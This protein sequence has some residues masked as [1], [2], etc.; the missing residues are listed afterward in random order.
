M[1]PLRLC[2]IP[3]GEASFAVAMIQDITQRKEAEAELLAQAAVNEHQA[4]HDALTGLANRTSFRSASSRP[5]GATPQ[6]HSRRSGDHGPRRVQG[7]QRLSRP[8]RRRPLLVELGRRLKAAVRGSDTV[9]RLGGDE[10]GVLLPETSGRETCCA[11]V[12]RIQAAI[13]SPITLHGLSLS[14]EA[15]IGIALYP[16]DGEDVETLLRKRRR[17]DVPRQRGEVR[18]GVLRV[19]RSSMTP[20]A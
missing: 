5:S 6:R 16:D 19:N 1:P 17:G 12:E 4:L 3:T 18:L 13:E 20:R 9:A 7:D 10:F 2:T 14:L 15:S 11:A 8:C